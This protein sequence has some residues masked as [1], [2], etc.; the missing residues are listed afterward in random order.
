VFH[1]WRDLGLEEGLASEEEHRA[2]GLPG[3]MVTRKDWVKKRFGSVSRVASV[4]RSPALLRQRL[5]LDSESRRSEADCK[6]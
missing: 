6:Y 1:E 2:W 4:R 3:G 5:A